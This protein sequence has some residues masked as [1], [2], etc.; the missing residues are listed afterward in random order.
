MTAPPPQA[1]HVPGEWAG[2]RVILCHDW[3]TG[4]RG[5]ERVLEL[6]CR[7]F[8][9]A[10][11]LS[12]FADPD[13]ISETI[14][15]HSITTSLLQQ[16]PGITRNYRLFLPLFPWAIEHIPVPDAD[17]IISTSHCVAKGLRPPVNARHLCYCFT[18]MRYAWTFY[19]EYFGHSR[20]KSLAAAMLLPPL[21]AWDRKS[22][23]RVD[24]FVA[25]S[26]HIRRRLRDFYGREAGVVYPPVDVARLTP[27]TR[28]RQ[29]FDLVVSA[30]VP[31]KRLDLAVR[32]Y[33]RSGYPLTIVGTGSERARL[34]QY[35][36]AH[37][38]F[39]GWQ[40]DDA[41]VNLYR[42]CRLLVFPGEE[43][44][45]LVPLEAQACGCPV[46]AYA[47]GGAL[48]TV[49][50]GVSGV[51]FREQTETALLQAVNRAGAF[52]WNTAAIRAHAETFS[53]QRF[54]DGLAREIHACLHP[55]PHAGA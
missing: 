47:R 18:P 10:H 12:L 33:T 52:P 35:A 25:I 1:L 49:K 38:R 6:L 7:A 13:A 39:L 31:Y 15:A 26:E 50:E 14:G 51:F 19:D 43:D 27:D 32:A 9:H 30:L 46:V 17:L 45:G 42:S 24:T 40:P 53:P 23:Q 21:R 36:G 55:S 41:V 5:G 11:I 16:I 2:L 3:L 22:A 4:M 54:I 34:Q 44:F 8:P 37:I 29:E 20:L 48:E 28:T